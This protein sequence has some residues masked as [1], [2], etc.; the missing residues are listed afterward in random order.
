[1]NIATFAA[2]AT[3][4]PA[5]SL[6]CQAL[7]RL[8]VIRCRTRHDRARGGRVGNDT[9]CP[10]RTPEDA[11]GPRMTDSDLSRPGRPVNSRR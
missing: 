7:A 5:Y 10:I 11:P 8:Q 1:M 2:T 6:G 3:L 4:A 9:R